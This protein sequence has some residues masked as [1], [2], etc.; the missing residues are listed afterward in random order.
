MPNSVARESRHPDGRLPDCRLPSLRPTD[1]ELHCVGF[2]AVS[3]LP[4]PECPPWLFGEQFSR[5]V[6]SQGLARVHQWF[7]MP[8]SAAI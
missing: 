7:Y 8:G 4:D 2:S 3:T 5:L 6:A 1:R